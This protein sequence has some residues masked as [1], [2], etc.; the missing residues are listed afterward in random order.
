[1]GSGFSF[2]SNQYRLELEGDE[3]FVDLL[4]FN[5]KLKCLMTYV[6]HLSKFISKN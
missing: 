6:K 4:F 1:M 2:I 5:R 3:Y